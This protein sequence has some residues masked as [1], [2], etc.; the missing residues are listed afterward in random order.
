MYA[1]GRPE[2][3]SSSEGW[4]DLDFRRTFAGKSAVTNRLGRKADGNQSL[5]NVTQEGDS[6]VT[7]VLNHG[8]DTRPRLFRSVSE[9]CLSVRKT[10]SM[11]RSMRTSLKQ[12]PGSFR[13]ATSWWNK[14]GGLWDRLR[15]IPE[16]SR[17]GQ[18]VISLF[19]LVPALRG[20]GYGQQLTQY[21]EG[22]FRRHGVSEYHLRVS[23]TNEPALH[24]YR[25]CGLVKIREEQHQH[26]M[27][28]MGK[29]I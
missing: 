4:A 14:M 12:E 28:R 2:W 24:F 26:V 18:L 15:C 27:W 13:A 23:P 11:S 6:Y 20:T 9:R 5:F 8:C 10:R 1:P 25:K 19:C 17:A 7:D 16:N 21:A 3:C 29:H 22:V